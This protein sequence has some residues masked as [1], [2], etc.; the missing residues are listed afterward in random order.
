MFS[1]A[2]A[3]NYFLFWKSKSKMAVAKIEYVF[4]GILKTERINYSSSN[5]QFNELCGCM[6]YAGNSFMP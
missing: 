3:W 5:V 1:D 4:Q 2:V 6:V